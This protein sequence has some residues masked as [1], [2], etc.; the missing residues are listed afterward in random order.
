VSDRPP[1]QNQ[2]STG[3]E[4]PAS[5]GPPQ[6]ALPVPQEAQTP[7]VTYAL[8]AMTG[9][10]FLLQLMGP[11]IFG[12][13][14]LLEIGIKENGLIA[15]G[16]LWRLFTPMFLHGSIPHFMFNMYALFVFGRTLEPYYGHTRFLA[17]YL[18]TGFAGNV[19]SMMLTE[20][21]SLGSSTAI[22]GLLGAEG[23][24]LYQNRKLL[25][26]RGRQALNQLI[27]VAIL[28][29]VIGLSPQI[30][31]WGHIGGLTAGVLFAWFAGPLIEVQGIPPNA[32]IV[33]IRHKS[34]V[35]TTALWV[36]AL[37]ALLAF[38]TIAFR[39]GFF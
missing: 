22:F 26:R 14:L 37:F 27:T 1:S 31:N 3:Y 16:Q 36:A 25:G 7:T 34:Q 11:Q 21:P 17:L 15:A 38:V 19:F 4:T 5:Q 28:N 30:D 8:L 10:A 18:I 32:S 24:F 20:A 33:D 9:F 2:L 13:D 6:A 23:V 12:F 29:L 35:T 39:S